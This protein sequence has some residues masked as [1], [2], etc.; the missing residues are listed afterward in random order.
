[1]FAQICSKVEK[2]AR[3]I[4]TL[5]IKIVRLILDH[6]LFVQKEK[7]LARFDNWVI[8]LKVSNLAAAII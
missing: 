7:I 3:G 8:S 4:T 2:T 5:K 1:M 6:T